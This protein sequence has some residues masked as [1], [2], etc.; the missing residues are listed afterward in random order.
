MVD[1]FGF[2]KYVFLENIFTQ[3]KNIEDSGHQDY[4]A[5]QIAW[6]LAK[7]TQNWAAKWAKS[8]QTAGS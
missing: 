3:I 6:G 2:P 1:T 8:G 4:R 7:S 5:G